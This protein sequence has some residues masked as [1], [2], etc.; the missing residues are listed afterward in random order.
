[1]VAGES[2]FVC[3][4]L[5]VFHSSVSACQVMYMYYLLGF[6]IYEKET[7]EIKRKK[8]TD[9]TFVLALDGDINFKP[10]AVLLLVDLMRKNK[11]LGAAC[12]R[13]HP[14]GTGQ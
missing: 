6:K 2:S 14:V 7:D 5:H 8:L 4:N 12:G 9:N 13:V 1:M 3:S 10:E 11:T